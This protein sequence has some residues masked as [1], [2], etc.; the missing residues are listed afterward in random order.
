MKL[1]DYSLYHIGIKINQGI[2]LEEFKDILKEFAVAEGYSLKNKETPSMNE[3]FSNRFTPGRENIAE[4]NGVTIYINSNLGA[5]NFA[6]KDEKEVSRIAPNFVKFLEEKNY[7]VDSIINFF[8]IMVDSKFENEKSPKEILKLKSTLELNKLEKLG[9]VSIDTIKFSGNGNIEQEGFIEV[10]I[11]TNPLKPS[12]EFMIKIL[13]RSKN[14]E[15]VSSFYKEIE[16][17]INS[18]LNY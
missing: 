15:V 17:S 4:K 9:D 7:E 16:S 5:I 2:D 14:I 11:G 18:F 6:G 12:K 8:E 1:K 13:K 10:V 3:V